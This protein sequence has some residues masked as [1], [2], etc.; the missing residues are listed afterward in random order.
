MKWYLSPME[1]HT[2][3]PRQIVRPTN[4]PVMY[5]L[6]WTHTDAHTIRKN[7]LAYI[8]WQ[9]FLNIVY[10]RQFLYKLFTPWNVYSDAFDMCT[11]GRSVLCLVDSH[12]EGLFT[13]KTRVFVCC[14]NS[15][16]DIS[17]PHTF[18]S[19]NGSHLN[20]WGF[21][22]AYSHQRRAFFLLRKFCCGYIKT[23]YI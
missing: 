6:V 4:T 10:L 13:P 2:K 1:C 15:A 17:K 20:V 21:D 19:A 18:K 8:K 3:M 9:I 7:I 14:G 22:R 23:P 11:A 16:A 5:G 12:T